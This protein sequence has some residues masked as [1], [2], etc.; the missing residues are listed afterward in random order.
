MYIATTSWYYDYLVIGFASS[1]SYYICI[2]FI[3]SRSNKNVNI[4]PS[5]NDASPETLPYIFY[6]LYLWIN[7]CFVAKLSFVFPGLKKCNIGIISWAKFIEPYGFAD[8]KLWCLNFVSEGLCDYWNGNETWISNVVLTARF[9][10]N[11]HQ[12]RSQSNDLESQIIFLI[13]GN[14]IKGTNQNSQKL[15]VSPLIEGGQP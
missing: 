13:A 4:K 6:M 9:Y 14:K 12:V 15:L 11:I 8:L 1:I 5:A 7:S 10:D 2:F 3:L